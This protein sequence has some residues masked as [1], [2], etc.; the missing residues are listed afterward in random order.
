M[1]VQV[2]N[3]GDPSKLVMNHPDVKK[4]Q[5]IMRMAIK[6]PGLS[7]EDRELLHKKLTEPGAFEKIMT[8]AMGA[9]I[10]YAIAKFLGLS[11]EMQMMM[12]MMG[13]GMGSIL[14]KATEHSDKHSTTHDKEKH[15]YTINP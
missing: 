14:L 12:S 10:V 2:T 3:L 9:S 6:D 1:D 5:E 11:K 15:V 7:S 13:F 8:G 4:Q